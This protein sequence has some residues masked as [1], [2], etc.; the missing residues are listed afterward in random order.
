MH[1]KK[2]VSHSLLILAFFASSVAYA[3]IN[4]PDALVKTTAN[5]VLEILKS[6]KDIQNGDMHKIGK[7]VEDK[8]ASQFDFDLMSGMVLGPKWAAATKEQQGQFIVEFRSLLIR[9]YSSALSKYRDQTIEYRPSRSTPGDT[10]VKVRTQIIQ[11]GGPSIP[12][13]YSLEK[14]GGTWKVYDVVIDG[15]SL[16]TT[17]HGQ[18]ADELKQNGIDG[19]IQ[20]LAEKNKKLS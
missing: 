5:D 15:I 8:V 20:K 7:L 10:E 16:V 18:F 9:V 12:L 13:N 1:M 17:Y 2:L 6:D 19:V 3:E 11:P 4:T 14:I